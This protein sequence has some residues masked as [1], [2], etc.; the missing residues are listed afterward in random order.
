MASSKMS[1]RRKGVAPI[2]ATRKS[3]RPTIL[4]GSRQ[5]ERLTSPGMSRTAA[6]WAL[7]EALP[8]TREGLRTLIAYAVSHD[9]DGYAW[10]DEWR[11][12]LLANLSEALP[13]LWQEGRV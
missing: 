2:C 11:E 9:T 3:S 6:A 5:N 4:D 7:L 13:Q 12:G 8:T 1:S 10:P